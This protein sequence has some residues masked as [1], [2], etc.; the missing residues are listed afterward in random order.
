MTDISKDMLINMLH[1]GIIMIAFGVITM[2]LSRPCRRP[3]SVIAPLCASWA[4]LQMSAK[5]SLTY[6]LGPYIRMEF[7]HFDRL[8]YAFMLVFCIIA[9]LNGIY[10][11]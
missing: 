6:E 2:L 11:G 8:T 4:F 9:V 5:S 10:G 3:L 7:I 1:P